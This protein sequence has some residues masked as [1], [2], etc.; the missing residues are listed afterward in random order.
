MLVEMKTQMF[1]FRRRA[2]WRD[3]VIGTGVELKEKVLDGL[4]GGAVLS[5]TEVVFVNGL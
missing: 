4:F 3:I 5:M 2:I 1:H